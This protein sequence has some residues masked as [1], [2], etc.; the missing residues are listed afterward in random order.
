MHVP[1]SHSPELGVISAQGFLLW[2]SI[3]VE[4]TMGNSGS[5][6]ISHWGWVQTH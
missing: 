6:S 2:S 1:N 4:G 3:K 5:L